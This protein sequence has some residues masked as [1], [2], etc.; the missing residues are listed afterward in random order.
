M[1]RTVLAGGAG[2]QLWRV[3]RLYVELFPD[4]IWPPTGPSE[5]WA[6]HVTAYNLPG[7][8]LGACLDGSLTVTLDPR[9]ALPGGFTATAFGAR[10]DLAPFSRLL[11]V[12]A[13]LP[14]GD[15]VVI[16]TAGLGLVKPTAP[17][18]FEVQLLDPASFWKDE[19]TPDTTT[20]NPLP[21]SSPY[22]TPG[23]VFG[24]YS[25]PTD[26]NWTPLTSFAEWWQ[27]AFQNFP[28]AEL[29]V[30]P[31]LVWLAGRP[32]LAPGALAYA[33]DYRATNLQSQGQ[34][35]PPY[36]T[37]VR[38]WTPGNGVYTAPTLDNPRAVGL[39]TPRRV[40]D[41]QGSVNAVTSTINSD[42][43]G[44]LTGANFSMSGVNSAGAQWR[45]N[46]PSLGS[47]ES[48]QAA[49]VSLNASVFT[50]TAPITVRLYMQQHYPNGS[51]GTIGQREIE[52][53]R[54]WGEVVKFDPSPKALAGADYVIAAVVVIGS[55]ASS[56]AQGSVSFAE[57]SYT[58]NRTTYSAS[59]GA[60]PV[61][62][63]YPF[64]TAASWT[65]R[66]PGVHRGPLAVSG[67]PIA[68]TQYATTI[69]TVD[70][71][72]VWTEV[73]CGPLPYQ[74]SPLKLTPGGF[75]RARGK[76]GLNR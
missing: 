74:S 11:R 9:A 17:N 26:G 31:D 53:T 44:T 57:A 12:I 66:L 13:V 51:F 63:Q 20:P 7:G 72:G 56:V 69:T 76:G 25:G 60:D 19:Y 42:W 64:T 47:N 18:T 38:R 61:G 28:D 23:R 70:A 43:T 37:R 22:T 30:G 52:I 49:S 54:P 71:Q 45:G 67:G 32:N 4:T 58:I 24:S 50:V 5:V 36:L 46:L 16:H 27:T 68:G 10:C 29:G 62:L 41:V 33:L 3:T 73:R 55:N 40:G 34:E 39:F 35:I 65:F 15:E 6:Q 2:A 1:T 21:T 48:L 59:Y 8:K 14:N 75:I